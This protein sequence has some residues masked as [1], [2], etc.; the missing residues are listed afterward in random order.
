MTDPSD[1]PPLDYPPPPWRARGELWMSA[2][3][4]R[5]ALQLPADLTPLGS[6]H[7]LIAVLVRYTEGTLR[8]DEFAVG[9]MARRGRHMGM[10]C[11]RI[12][13]DSASSLHGGRQLWGI[14][15]E[16]ANFSWSEGSVRIGDTT[17]PIATL[18]VGSHSRRRIPISRVPSVGFGR[19]D[20]ERT[21]LTG[22]IAG[23]LGTSRI[24][25]REWDARLPGL[26]SPEPRYTLSVSRAR[27]VFPE[28]TL[29]GRVDAYATEQ[30]HPVGGSGYSP[31]W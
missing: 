22:R 8:Y 4:T 14:Q 5:E 11:H 2:F 6:R 1:P 25:P 12:W 27:F 21:L 28:G 24:S 19:I 26:A 30:S 3:R 10:L 31:N 15:K 20:S 13:V 17:G 9:S 16:L 23:R 18:R 29:L 7:T